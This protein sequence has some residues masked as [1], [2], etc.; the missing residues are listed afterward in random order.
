MREKQLELV[1]ECNVVCAESKFI[2]LY[3]QIEERG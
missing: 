2:Y 1:E 3:V